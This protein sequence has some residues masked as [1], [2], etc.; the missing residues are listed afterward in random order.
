MQT[1]KSGSSNSFLTAACTHTFSDA[2]VIPK[3]VGTP[4]QPVTKERCRSR[5]EK[6]RPQFFHIGIRQI[7]TTRRSPRMG[8]LTY[9]HRAGK[10]RG[11][12][13]RGVSHV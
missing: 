5:A 8:P 4:G 13:Q 6:K 12:D 3:A 9:L 10:R 11:G 2:F 1:P 7:C